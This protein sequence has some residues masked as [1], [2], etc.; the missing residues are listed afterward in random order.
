ML[1]FINKQNLDGYKILRFVLY[2]SGLCRHPVIVSWHCMLLWRKLNPAWYLLSCRWHIF[3]AWVLMGFFLLPSFSETSR[4]HAL[5]APYQ[6]SLS[7]YRFFLPLVQNKFF[8]C[9]FQY[10]FLVHLSAFHPRKHLI[11]WCISMFV[12]C[13]YVFLLI[14]LNF[15]VNFS[16]LSSISLNIFALLFLRLTA[17]KVGFHFCNVSL[18]SVFF[19]LSS[20]S[21]CSLIYLKISSVTWSNYYSSI[22]FSSAFLLLP[23][24]TFSL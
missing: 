11:W 5:I 14:A 6:F 16:S 12:V 24:L 21:S 10:F 7:V 20:N 9:I 13:I 1:S 17:C 4:T 2:V 18:S 23:V 15:L 3:S 8:N 19:P 22:Y